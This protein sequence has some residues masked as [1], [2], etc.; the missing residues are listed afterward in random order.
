MSAR[1]EDL[2]SH[3][4]RSDPAL[5]PLAERMRPRDLDGYVG[6]EHLTGPG[7]LLRRVVESDRIPSMIFWGPPGTGK[8]T[9]AR[10]IAS[11]TGAHFDTLSATDAGV[12]DLRKA[13]ERARERRDYQGRATLLFVDEIHRFNKA[14]QDALLPHVEAGVCTLIGA[15][16]ENPS[17]EVNAALLSRARVVQLRALGIPQLV[18]ILRAAL[19]HDERG[20]GRRQVQASD[21]LLGAIALASQGDARRALNSLELAVDLVPDADPD[22]GEGEEGTAR[23]LSPELVAE[24][25][26]QS[27]LRYD[28]DGE[29]HYNIASAFIKSMRAS[30]PDAAV[31]WMARMLE[32]G[33]PLEFVARRLVIFAAEDVGNA[34]PQAIVVAQS[35]ADAARFVGMPEAVLPLS[36]AAVF[37]SLAPKSNATIKAYFAARKEVRRRGPLPVPMEIR[38]AVTKLMKQAGYGSGYRYP[39]DLEGNVD[40]RHRSHLPE[41]LRDHLGR[42][43]GRRY[44]HST[45]YGWEGRAEQRLAR[46]RGE[47]PPGDSGVD[48]KARPEPEVETPKPEVET[49]Q[50]EPD[51]SNTPQSQPGRGDDGEAES[52]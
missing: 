19:E 2:F 40:P 37:L 28:R 17:F 47:P 41:R 6:Q 21:R 13:V 12:K 42:G 44:V 18:D 23:E 14:Q 38:N 36:Q 27:H 32:A 16:T 8:T 35:C 49:P 39:H 5:V 15:T 22:A 10:I 34:E 48:P 7:R 45:R 52:G 43:D 24:A 33:E 3:A 30:D 25:L 51:N 9:L 4:R 11:R 46:L 1:D 20:L 50:S 26:G 29:E 31:Y